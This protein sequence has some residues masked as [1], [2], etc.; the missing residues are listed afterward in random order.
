MGLPFFT[1]K[2]SKQNKN[3]SYITSNNYASST[4]STTGSFNNITSTT[5]TS[6]TLTQQDIQDAYNYLYQ[7]QGKQVLKAQVPFGDSI[8]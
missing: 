5:A 6:G 4:S 7:Q 3:K 2:T 8:F 1:T